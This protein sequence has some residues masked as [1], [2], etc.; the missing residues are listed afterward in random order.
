MNSQAFFKRKS[1]GVTYQSVVERYKGTTG[2][3]DGTIGFCLHCMILQ[4]TWGSHILNIQVCFCGSEKKPTTWIWNVVLYIIVHLPVLNMGP[5]IEKMLSNGLLSFSS[6][7][8]IPMCLYSCCNH[9]SRNPTK[10]FVALNINL[11]LFKVFLT[12]F[13]IC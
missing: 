3:R 6:T 5:C 9:S 12:L 11:N 7:Y 1:L 2:A 8:L 13:C 10:L 4:R